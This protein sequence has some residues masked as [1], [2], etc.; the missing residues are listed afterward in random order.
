MLINTYKI[1]DF[2][3]I[4]FK[5]AQTAAEFYGYD[6][7]LPGSSAIGYQQ[8]NTLVILLHKNIINDSISLHIVC[9]AHLVGGIGSLNITVNN[10]PTMSSIAISDDGNELVKSGDSAVQGTFAWGDRTDGGAI[11]DIQENLNSIS[12][13]INSFTGLDTLRFVSSSG[14]I[15]DKP[16]VTGI[17]TLDQLQE[18]FLGDI[19]LEPAPGIYS[20]SQTVKA[21]ISDTFPVVMTTTGTT[22][23]SLAK[24]IAY[25]TLTPP[26][27]FIATV[28]DGRGNVLFDGGFPKWYNTNVNINWTV[29]GQMTGAFKYLYNA[30]SFIANTDKLNTGNNKV[31]ILGDANASEIF[32]V[33]GTGANSFKTSFDK[34]CSIAGFIPTYKTRGTYGTQLNPTFAELDEFCCVILMSSVSTSSQLITNAGVNNLLIYREAGNGIFLITD[35]GVGDTGFYR[36]ANFIANRLGADFIGN[37]NRTPVNVGFLRSTYGDH[38]LYQNLADNEYIQAGGSE[39]RVDLI[40]TPTYDPTTLPNQLISNTG[41]TD[42]NFLLMT[43]D[44]T[45]KTLKYTYGIGVAEAVKF[46][47]SSNEKLIPTQTFSRKFELKLNVDNS[48]LSQEIQGLIKIGDEVIGEF[49]GTL[50]EPT[51]NF[52]GDNSNIIDLINFSSNTITVQVISPMSYTTSV[53]VPIQSINHNIIKVSDF[54][55]ALNQYDLKGNPL[56]V[57]HRVEEQ[58][59]PYLQSLSM[60]QLV[61][62]TKNYLSFPPKNIIIPKSDVFYIDQDSVFNTSVNTLLY[63]DKLYASGSLRFDDAYDVQNGTLHII[64]N[65]LTFTPTVLGGESGSF[66]YKV[67]NDENNLSATSLVTINVRMLSTLSA[68]IYK[69]SVEFDTAVSTFTPPT[70]LDIFN[71]WAR[72]DGANYFENISTATGSAANWKYLT[73]P[74]RIEQPDNT[75]LGCGFISPELLDTFTFESTLKSVDSDDDT[76]GLI[77]AFVRDNGVNKSLVAARTKGGQQPTLGWGVIYTENGAGTPTWVIQQMSVGGVSG[78][79]SGSSSRVKIDR[80]EDLIK[81]YTSNWNNETIETSSE[82]II[83]LN[84]D[85]RLEVFK[86][87]QPYGY[88][89]HSQSNSTYLNSVVTGAIN[90]NQLL[91]YETGEIMDYVD[92]QWVASSATIQDETGYVRLVVNPLTSERFLIKENSIEFLG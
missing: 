56:K 55:N 58:V 53:I 43:S 33:L 15:F 19:Y 3:T 77:I 17:I 85:P 81:C 45:I 41:Y 46:V 20:S 68:L 7:T 49:Q 52:Y 29:F 87:K 64:N 48:D 32:S 82:I 78:G 4:P 22:S 71:T 39:S 92:G 79:F 37:Y 27:P 21:T 42:L 26:N 36:T 63:N 23:P 30:L 86:G 34:V 83:D 73:N 16:L 69:D 54:V 8:A 80:K 35:D 44:G 13:S 18:E 60:A 1:D 14:S 40:I 25:D 28:Q 89:T 88:Y 9:N 10:L 74:E 84:S 2:D 51:Y 38:I 31:L 59:S 62:K 12:I 76:I 75:S 57:L 66:R 90:Y 72:I 65:T 47:D 50:G 24:Y 5:S 11:Q 6:A 70:P 61:Q 91:N 67:V